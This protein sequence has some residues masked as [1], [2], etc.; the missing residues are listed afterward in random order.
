MFCVCVRACA[1]AC[2]R[3]DVRAC[4]R[5][6]VC[7]CVCVCMCVCV[8]V[9]VLQLGWTSILVLFGWG[10]QIGVGCRDKS[11]LGLRLGYLGV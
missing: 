1:R 5:V 10:L 6:C 3:A 2:V 9:C 11:K 8:C 7:V 4:A